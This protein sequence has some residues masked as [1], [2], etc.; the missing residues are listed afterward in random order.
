VDLFL[1]DEFGVVIIN[2]SVRDRPHAGKL[3]GKPGSYVLAATIPAVLRPG[4]YTAR[5]WIG[6]D[7][8]DMVEQDL[9]AIR[10]APMAD[11]PQHFMK[12]ARTVQPEIEWTVRDEP[13]S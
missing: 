2:D 12:R 10:I 6:N 13:L 7:Y 5:C 9:L 4:R 11:D 1:V 3:S 8:E